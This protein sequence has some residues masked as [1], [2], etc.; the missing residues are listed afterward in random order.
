MAKQF[1]IY[2]SGRDRNFPKAAEELKVEIT[3]ID[4]QGASLFGLLNTGKVFGTVV[5]YLSK[6]FEYNATGNYSNIFD[7]KSNNSL[8]GKILE[9]EVQ[10]NIANYGYLT[11]KMYHNGDSPTID[12]SFRCYAGALTDTYST[13][14][15]QGMINPVQIANVL[16]NATLPRVGKQGILNFTSI[17]AA[18]DSKSPLG[19]T[20]KPVANSIKSLENNG[21][22][23]DVVNAGVAG[24]MDAWDTIKSTKIT[25]LISK[26]P[27]VCNVKIGNIFEKSMMVVK[28][29]S[30]KFS[31]EFLREGVPLYADFDVTLQSLFNSSTLEN[32][33]DSNTEKIFGSGLNGN[34]SKGSRVSF[35]YETP[36]EQQIPINQT[37]VTSTATMNRTAGAGDPHQIAP[38]SRSVRY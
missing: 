2:N 31:K 23:G 15:K 16:I 25:D 19:A 11:K 28:T 7:V 5:G 37:V 3:L 27:P 32:G 4:E 12:I 29:V 1:S 26:K 9:D 33:T 18:A 21:S 35:D 38:G 17:N 10:G 36:P 30:V 14:P 22:W 13:S 34:T 6:E 24:V 20:L 8:L